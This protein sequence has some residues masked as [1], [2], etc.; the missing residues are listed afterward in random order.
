MQ[1]KAKNLKDLKYSS[2]SEFWKVCVA[3]IFEDYSN[4]PK[5]TPQK[6]Q[7]MFEAAE[8]LDDFQREILESTDPDI[9]MTQAYA[10]LSKRTEGH[11]YRLRAMMGDRCRK[12]YSDA[13]SL[14]NGT[15]G[16]AILI[17]TPQGA[18]EPR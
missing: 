9:T 12:T 2:P 17:N 16:F 10:V 14:K 5:E 11:W 8:D 13:G 1:G 15:G 6:M 18:G 3:H 7:A 4:A